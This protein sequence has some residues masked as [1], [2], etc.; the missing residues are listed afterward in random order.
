MSNRFCFQCGKDKPREGGGLKMICGSR[1]FV[2]SD[3]KRPAGRPV[4]D[5]AKKKRATT[6]SLSPDQQRKLS[7]LGGSKFIQALL[8]AS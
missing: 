8:D 5:P 4:V 7:K 2:C 3:C 6:V 1:C